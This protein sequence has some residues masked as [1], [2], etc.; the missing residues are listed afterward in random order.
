MACEGRGGLAW[1]LAVLLAAAVVGV[2]RR[3]GWLTPSGQGAAF[4]LGVWVFGAG[5]WRWS[6]PL[7]AFFLSSS[8]LTRFHR[9]SKG[10]KGRDARQVLANGLVPAGALALCAWWPQGAWMAYTG[11]LAVATADTWATELGMGS[12]TRPW[13]LRLKRPVPPGTSGAVSRRGVLASLAGAGF[14]GLWAAGLFPGAEGRLVSGFLVA[15]VGVVGAG[16]DSLMGAFLQ[17]RFRCRVCGAVLEARDAHEHAGPMDVLFGLPW[18]TNNL[19]NFFTNLWGGLMAGG[20]W[21]FL[22]IL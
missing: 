21:F 5:G 16:L 9:S 2:A 13:S 15:L 6:L 19:V 3:R 1:L 20:L 8:L 7:L 22:H 11:A 14:L 18:M 12:G 4:L 17:G 10:A